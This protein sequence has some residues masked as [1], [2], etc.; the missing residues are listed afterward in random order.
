MEQDEVRAGEALRLGA[1]DARR[2]AARLMGSASTER[3]KAS[4]A[5]NGRLG[6]R[7]RSLNGGRPLRPLAEI[8]CTCGRGD[9][10]DHPTTCPRGRVIRYRQKRGLPLQ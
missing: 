1:E 2:E 10:P 4:S 9:G 5:A 7:P 6:G 3:K 8:E